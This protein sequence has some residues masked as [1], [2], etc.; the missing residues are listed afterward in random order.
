MSELTSSKQLPSIA[1][2]IEQVQNAYRELMPI[3]KRVS[4]RIMAARGR[5]ERGGEGCLLL[6]E[7]LAWPAT[8]VC[9]CFATMQ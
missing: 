6:V 8:H 5:A 2:T 3:L 7:H 4:T 9:A 1:R